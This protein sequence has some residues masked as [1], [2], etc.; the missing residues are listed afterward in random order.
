MEQ[1]GFAPFVSNSNGDVCVNLAGVPIEQVDAFER[2]A[3][4]LFVQDDLLSSC[5]YS[6]AEYNALY[7]GYHR[8]LMQYPMLPATREMAERARETW[9][10]GLGS[11]LSGYLNVEATRLRRRAGTDPT[12]RTISEAN[13][14]RRIFVD[15]PSAVQRGNFE[16]Q[17]LAVHQL[18]PRLC[19]MDRP[20][21]MYR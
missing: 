6:A 19:T 5:G 4:A 15:L 10:E 11:A 17:M 20:V 14:Y 7:G 13:E 8:L 21:G 16:E 2:C 3:R 12:F 9:T 18:N 1:L